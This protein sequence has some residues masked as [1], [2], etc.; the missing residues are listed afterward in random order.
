MKKAAFLLSF[1][2]AILS[3]C[4]SS[5]VAIVVDAETDKVIYFNETH[6]SNCDPL[7]GN[8]ARNLARNI[9]SAL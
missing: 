2:V 3:S 9:F 7:A 4:S 8:R 6:D 5:Y 1:A